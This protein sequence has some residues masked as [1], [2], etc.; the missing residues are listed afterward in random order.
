MR[1]EI[2]KKSKYWIERQR[3]LLLYHYCLQY[4]SWK[5]EY[6][7][8]DGKKA[9]VYD[10][11]PHG[12]SVGS[13]TESLA[14]KRAE[15]SAQIQGLEQTAYEADPAL[16]KWI[17]KGVTDENATYTYLQMM[18]DIPCSRNTYYSR[19]RYF[20]WLLDKKVKIGIS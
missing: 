8:L 5:D 6:S 1:S 10:G 20:F 18:M 12:T 11:M 9:M 14:I 17:L 13:P 16:A 4:Q 3:Y 19:R 15:L 2:S 7:T